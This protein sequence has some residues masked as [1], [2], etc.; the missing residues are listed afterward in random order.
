[1][2]TVKA[3]LNG[4]RGRHQ[5]PGV[6]LSPSELAEEAAA[7]EEAVSVVHVHPRDAD[8]FE[9]LRWEDIRAAVVAIR[10]RCPGL[11]VGVSTR[12]E[13]VRGPDR[14]ELLRQWSGPPDG[15]DLASVNWHEPDATEVAAVLAERG[16]GIE[17]GL[18]TP[19][20]ARKLSSSLSAGHRPDGLTR[21]LVEAIP[22]ISPGADGVDAASRILAE[23]PDPPSVDLVVHGEQEWA[24]PVLRWAR[25]TGRGI[26]A[27]LED[28]LTGP[29][30]EQVPGNAALLHYALARGTTA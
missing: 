23:L 15:P 9:S 1:M 2:P 11:V 6:P 12:E 27:G 13:I 3:C 10:A 18:F 17:A 21:V 5:H 4:D 29:A 26:R 20:A 30:G 28:M 24:W 22:G 19:D 25:Q 16:I 14:L 8:G 7:V